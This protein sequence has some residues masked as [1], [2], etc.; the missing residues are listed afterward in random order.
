MI[1]PDH[2]RPKNQ[3]GF[4]NPLME[5]RLALLKQ[6]WSQSD[7]LRLESLSDPNRGS[8]EY[9]HAIPIR[10]CGLLLS[11]D[12]LRVNIC[13]RLGVDMIQ[14]HDCIKCGAVVTSKGSHSLSCKFSA[15]RSP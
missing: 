3:A 13:L 6:N 5:K 8:S 10:S 11:N 7:T 9:L 2:D 1:F 12:E 14:P 15:V 4:D